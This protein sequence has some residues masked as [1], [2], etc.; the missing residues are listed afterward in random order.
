LGDRPEQPREFAERV[1]EAGALVHLTQHRPERR[2]KRR[3][4]V[5]HRSRHCLCGKVPGP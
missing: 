4:E 3:R 1:G 2:C 5:R